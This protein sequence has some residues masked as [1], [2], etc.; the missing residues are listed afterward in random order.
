MSLGV[1]CITPNHKYWIHG[2]LTARKGVYADVHA[3]DRG[4]G[5]AGR[6][7]GGDGEPL[8]DRWCILCININE[9]LFPKPCYCFYISLLGYS[10]PFNST[11]S[12]FTALALTNLDNKF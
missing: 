7:G 3:P 5:V 9:M 1:V 10:T 12:S 2:G 11:N 8:L 6:S 4:T